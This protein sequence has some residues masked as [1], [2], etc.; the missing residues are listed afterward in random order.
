MS[1]LRTVVLPLVLL[2]CCYPLLAQNI[3]ISG[4]VTDS[5]TQKPLPYASIG[6]SKL[7]KGTCSNQNGRFQLKISEGGFNQFITVS[8]MGYKNLSIP[9]STIKNPL[10]IK[11]APDNYQLNQVT[12][13]PNTIQDLLRR[14]YRSIPVNYPVQPV[15]Y[16][17]F[18]RETQRANDTL[19]L[20]FTEAILNVYKNT[21]K[22]EHNFGQVH[23]VKSRKNNFPGLD[24]VNNVRF[25][26]GPFA[27]I[28]DDFVFSRAMYINPKYFKYFRYKL[29][30]TIGNNDDELLVIGFSGNKDTISGLNGKLYLDKKSLA[31]LRVE[32]SMDSAY[33]NKHKPLISSPLIKR[34]ASEY[35]VGYAKLNGIW[36][37][38]YVDYKSEDYNTHCKKKIKF[39]TEYITTAVHAD[40]VKPIPYD[41]QLEY[42]DVISI[43][44]EK[45]SD[46]NWKDYNLLPADTALDNQ[47]KL[48]Y[49]S[50]KSKQLLSKQY[51]SV[52]KEPFRDKLVKIL[53]KFY[54]TLSVAY[55]PFT[56]S[57]G[58]YKLQ[59]TDDNGHL[60]N[61]ANTLKKIT[62]SLGLSGK[63]GY[64]ITKTFSAYYA[65]L[66]SLMGSQYLDSW[67]LGIAYR[68]PLTQSGRHW[69]ID[70]GIGYGE[71]NS[72]L[73]LGN[74]SNGSSSLN[75]GGKTFDASRIDVC[76]GKRQTGIVPE[77]SVSCKKGRFTEWFLSVSRMVAFS[78]DDMA[79]FHES[80]GFFLTRKDVFLPA[81]DSHI[82]QSL[83]N[84]P[85]TMP[86]FK[87]SPY[88]IALGLRLSL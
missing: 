61:K 4:I 60:L 86:D 72:M 34:G 82:Q 49:T 84:L 54:F 50:E 32:L 44:A 40:S 58:D 38:S 48:V 66:S 55:S 20:N 14:A 37:L 47:L 39:D 22:D 87:L 18:F 79:R 31:Y 17:G 27:P 78:T 5:L 21:Y 26:G 51:N 53:S 70:M 77:I 88:R 25:Y 30:K 15:A 19:Y 2:T 65:Q 69:F 7:G 56:T 1:F 6:I 28:D 8:C 81:T 36:H 71:H 52:N 3:D 68:I 45:Y 23:M 43:K 42:L 33:R 85:Q 16:E 12:V 83:D 29:L 75:I 9:V 13:L 80:K 74:A 63:Y 41:K 24:T 11:L 57:G 62:Y 35:S 67:D 59:Y 76:I 46:S 10:K 73:D 64:N